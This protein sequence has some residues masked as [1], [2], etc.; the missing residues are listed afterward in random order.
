MSA[1]ASVVFLV[2]VD[3]TLLDNDGVLEDLRGQVE[4]ELGQACWERYRAI[5]AGLWAE[6]GYRD[7]LGA[8]QQYRV[9]H[10]YDARLPRLALLL[11]DYPFGRRLY[12]RAQEVLAQ[13]RAWGPTVLLTDGDVV[14]QPRKLQRSGLWRSVEGR[15]L[16][17]VHK[18]RELHDIE[19][20]YPADHY[21]L[22]DDKPTILGAMKR[23]WGRRVTTV[24]PRQGQYARDPALLSGQPPPDLT[25]AR[26][27]D[28]LGYD[29]QTLVAAGPWRYPARPK[30]IPFRPGLRRAVTT[31]MAVPGSEWR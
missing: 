24:L 12:P 4:E 22:I 25:V 27:A 26:I 8:L 30:V 5:L 10:P 17:Y 11:L 19:T 13:L 6:L 9:E 28:L 31:P 18:E 23:V 15:V 29:L 2:D 3:N 7:Y 16:I 1:T 20:R 21:V 14:F